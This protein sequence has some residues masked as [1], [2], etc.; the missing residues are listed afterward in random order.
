MATP[1]LGIFSGQVARLRYSG[2]GSRSLVVR[3]SAARDQY[4]QKVE[5]LEHIRAASLQT[6]TGYEYIILYRYDLMPK[7]DLI[8]PDH[9]PRLTYFSHD[10][11]Q[12]ISL[13]WGFLTCLLDIHVDCSANGPAAKRDA[14][15]CAPGAVTKTGSRRRRGYNVDSSWTKARVVARAEG[16]EGYSPGRSLEGPSGVPRGT[17]RG[18]GD[19]RGMGV[20]G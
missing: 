18:M 17:K 12:R 2:R 10:D 11:D 4:Q 9:E 8:M 1:R 15:P 3:H 20:S 5:I 14:G 6:G 13:P 19:E 7:P 16:S